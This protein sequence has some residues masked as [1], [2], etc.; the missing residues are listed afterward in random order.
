MRPMMRLV[1]GL[2]AL[3][4][5]FAGVALALPSYVNVARS[6][7]INAPESAVFPYINNLH[8]FN[9]WS[10]WAARDPQLQ[11]TF[12]GPEEG[13]GAKIEWTSSQRSVG[14]GSVTITDSNPNRHIDL[15]LALNGMEGAG[16]YDVVP[17]GSGS[18]L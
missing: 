6:V 7:V 12:S 14:D 18:K 11:A 15:A 5:I 13:K 16:Y 9:D 4:M 17:S 10:P 8:R 1:L 3:V 2:G